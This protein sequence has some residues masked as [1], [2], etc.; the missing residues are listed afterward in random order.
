MYLA[1]EQWVEK[2]VAP[3][4]IITPKY[5]KDGTQPVMTRP[6]C[7]YPQVAKYKGTGDTTDAANFA[8]AAAA[9]GTP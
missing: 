9:S 3:A 2:G 4:M 1:L 7:P 6:L 8:C 5:E